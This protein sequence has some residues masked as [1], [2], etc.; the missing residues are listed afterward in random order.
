MREKIRVQ[1]KVRMREE[2]RL[3]GGVIKIVEEIKPEEE[4]IKIQTTQGVQSILYQEMYRNQLAKEVALLE[5]EELEDLQKSREAKEK[6]KRLHETLKMPKSEGKS[7]TK[8]IKIISYQYYYDVHNFNA[9]CSL[10][11]A[12]F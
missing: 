12:T 3:E 7:R 11:L 6:R 4:T 1:E 2:A 9:Y 5:K 8:I 10:I